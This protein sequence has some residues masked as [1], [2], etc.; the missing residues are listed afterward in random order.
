MGRL[1]E[2]GVGAVACHHSWMPYR[3]IRFRLQR[4]DGDREIGLVRDSPLIDGRTPEV[5]EVVEIAH[6]GHAFQARVAWTR[7][8]PSGIDVVKVVEI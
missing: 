1:Q 3:F 5:G 2:V 4:F 7:R 6:H 8:T